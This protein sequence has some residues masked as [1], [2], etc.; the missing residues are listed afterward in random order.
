MTDDFIDRAVEH[1]FEAILP[2]AGWPCGE[3]DGDV[4]LDQIVDLHGR[5]AGKIEPVQHLENRG[6]QTTGIAHE[7]NFIGSLYHFRQQSAGRDECL[8]QTRVPA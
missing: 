2:F 5:H 3:V 1:E 6:K 7:R 8:Q 4:A